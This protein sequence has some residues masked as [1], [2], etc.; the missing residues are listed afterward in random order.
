MPEAGIS[1]L[2]VFSGTCTISLQVTIHGRKTEKMDSKR[3]F[4]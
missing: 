1:V 2:E 4:V 3:A